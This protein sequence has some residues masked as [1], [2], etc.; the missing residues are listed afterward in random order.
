MEICTI[1]MGPQE[2]KKGHI[3]AL[4]VTSSHLPKGEKYQKT[5]WKRGYSRWV[6]KDRD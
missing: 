3:S 1:N 6:L 2:K 4:T 5:S